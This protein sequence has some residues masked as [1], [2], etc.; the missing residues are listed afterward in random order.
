MLLLC[1]MG[2]VLIAALAFQC[3][4]VDGSTSIVF[5]LPGFGYVVGWTSGMGVGVCVWADHALIKV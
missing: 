5:W 4:A 3:T 2:N 1:T